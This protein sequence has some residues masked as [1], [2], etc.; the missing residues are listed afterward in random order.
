M[1]T[2]TAFRLTDWGK[3]GELVQVPRPTPGPR[4]VL[5]KVGGAGA[6]QSD[7]HL[8]HEFDATTAPW[9]PGFVLGHENAGWVAEAGSEVRRFRVGDAVAVMGA[10]GCGACERCSSGNDPYCDNPGSADAPGGG[11]GLGLDGGMAE[12][13][14][15]RDADRHLVSLPES[16]TPD[17]AAPLTD[18]GVTPY[19]AVKRS[20]AKLADPRS[21]ALVIGVGGLGAFGVQI[22]SALTSARIIAVDTR[23]E[24]RIRAADDGAQ[25]A[26]APDN[27]TA[28]HLRDLTGG[29][30]VDVVLDF[31]GNQA[32][33]DLAGAVVRP[34]GDLTVIGAGGAN[35]TV[36]FGVLPY[37]VSVQTTFWGNLTEL[38]EVVDLAAR[39]VIRPRVTHYPLTE[40]LTAYRDLAAGKVDGRAVIRP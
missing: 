25:H 33:L 19:H 40:T 30:G 18:A 7:L 10:W 31:V 27:D 15:V 36:G 32:T 16:L 11:G 37:E 3:E 14:V 4:D 38:A 9:A 17:L 5:L 23:E 21:T 2:M 29:K 24:A 39:G 22:L 35:A 12:Y 6:C 1:T 28:S 13:M 34:L 20:L 26:F 8:M